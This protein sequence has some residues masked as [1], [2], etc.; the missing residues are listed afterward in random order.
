MPSIKGIDL[1][2]GITILGADDIPYQ[3]SE[4]QIVSYL[5]GH[6][7]AHTEEQAAN[8]LNV[9][10]LNKQNDQCKVHIYSVSPLKVGCIVAIVN[11]SEWDE[12]LQEWVTKQYVIPD[13]WWE[14]A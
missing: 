2:D 12:E 7:I 3:F 13:N 5:E 9:N 6:D 11:Y 4:A 8:W 10:V 14:S 1:S